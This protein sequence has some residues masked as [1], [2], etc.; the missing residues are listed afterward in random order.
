MVFSKYGQYIGNILYF[1]IGICF[2]IVVLV[3]FIGIEWKKMGCWMLL[4]N[5]YGFIMG[6]NFYNGI[7]LKIE[8]KSEN[9]CDVVVKG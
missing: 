5:M 7:F 9:R 4:V 3:V 6:D 1:M 8:D 2:S